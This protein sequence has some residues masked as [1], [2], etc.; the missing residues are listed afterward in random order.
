[1]TIT[2]KV[3]API[4]GEMISPNK[5]IGMNLSEAKK[6]DIQIGNKTYKMEQVFSLEESGS[7]KKLVLIGDLSHVRFVGRGMTEGSILVEGKAGPYLGDSMKGGEIVVKGD[8]DSWLGA[9]MLGGAIEIHGNAGNF[10]GAAYRGSLR[11]IK[12]GTIK[13]HG[14]CGSWAGLQSRGGLIWIDGDAGLLPGMHMSAGEVYIAGGCGG[15][16]GAEMI[17]GKIAVAGRLSGSVLPSFIYDKTSKPKIGGVKLDKQF[18]TFAGDIAQGGS[19]KLY[20]G[21][22]ANP[23]LKY[24]EE[25]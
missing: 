25:L 5:L 18:Y 3:G 1:M 2:K 16:P 15:I 4:F 24:L 17:G 22:E 21:V 23:H 9:R 7:E 8:A 6:L 12:N 20:I 13:I 11:G 19:G 10:V 14:S